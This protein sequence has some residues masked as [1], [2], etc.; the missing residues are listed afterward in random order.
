VGANVI[1]DLSRLL[2]RAERFAP[3]GIDRVE[4][5]YARHLLATEPER[6]DFAAWWGRRSLLP[7]RHAAA[8]VEALDLLWSGGAREAHRRASVLAFLLRSYAL[9]RGEGFLQAHIGRLGDGVVYLL[10]SHQWLDR[11]AAFFRLKQRSG[12]KLICFVHDL[13]PIEHP[14]LVRAGSPRR[15]RRRIE[16]VARL[17]DRIIVNSAGTARALAR[18]LGRDGLRAPPFIA[19]LGIDVAPPSLR[20]NVSGRAPAPLSPPYFVC[21]GTIEPRKNHRL[22]LAVWK[23]LPPVLGS[24]APRLVL[25]GR[26]GWRARAIMRPLKRACPPQGLVEER[27]APPD[28]ELT[29]LLAGA[30]ALLYPTFAEGFGLP[31]AE[32]LA[33][34]VPVLCSDLPEL[35]E[36][37]REVPEYLDPRDEAAWRG[38]VIA[39]AEPQSARRRAQLV[40]LEAWRAPSW[41][42]HFALVQ[43]LIEEV[44]LSPP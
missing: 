22:L 25:V 2:L 18:H 34:G 44:A 6:V 12:V 35:R 33:L 36:I 7:Y 19:P 24:R 43:P 29:R 40:R 3:T 1:L 23:S 32:A 15:H 9:M 21:V 27:N 10:V 41:K 31:V 17:A 11:P 39:Y 13:I 5:A 30:C 28:A 20:G 38:A 16:T 37:G 8:F 14:G 42:E 4:L 26:R